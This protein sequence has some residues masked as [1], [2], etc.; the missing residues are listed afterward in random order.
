MI[1]LDTNL[2]VYAHRADAP[3]HQ[4]TREALR[5]LVEGERGDWALPWPCVHEFL[6][7]VTRPLWTSP[8]TMADACA[9]ID[10]TLEAPA[11]TLIGE[12]LQHWSTLCTMVERGVVGPK[13]HDARIAAIC[14]DHGVRELWTVDR[15][16]SYFPQLSTRNP[17]AS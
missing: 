6:A 5:P 3:L 4:A 10:Q 15:D 9:F 1:A 17:L 16:F 7:T 13:V 8:T 11:L 14:V 2:L 12:T